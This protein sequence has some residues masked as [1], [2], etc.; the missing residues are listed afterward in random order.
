MTSNQRFILCLTSLLV[1]GAAVIKVAPAQQTAPQVIQAQQFQVVDKQ[2][3]KRVELGVDNEGESFVTLHDKSGQSQISL[4]VKP[5]GGAADI[6]ILKEGKQLA[7]LA[8]RQD[9]SLALVLAKTGTLLENGKMAGSVGMAVSP[10]GEAGIVLSR[11]DGKL[12]TIKP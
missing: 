12:R 8:V 2:G 5:T 4:A 7:F 1:V 10:E 6:S 3:V 9:G 11:R